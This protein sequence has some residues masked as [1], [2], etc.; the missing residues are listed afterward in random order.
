[1]IE[2]KILHCVQ[3]DNLQPPVIAS[4]CCD[5]ISIH[6]P[7]ADCHVAALL[8]KTENDLGEAKPRLT[9]YLSKIPASKR[10][11][12]Q[13]GVRFSFR[14]EPLHR[15]GGHR[16]FWSICRERGP[17]L[18]R[19]SRSTSHPEPYLLRFQG[20]RHKAVPHLLPAIS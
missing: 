17:A 16:P 13:A 9:G 6:K 2:N 19:V 20:R 12:D 4:R 1:M 11:V 10:H 3:N 5:A 8:A 14:R 7:K 15:A 18:V